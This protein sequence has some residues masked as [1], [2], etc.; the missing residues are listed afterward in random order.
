VLEPLMIAPTSTEEKMGSILQL[1]SF[2]APL[3]P[4]YI[5][6]PYNRIGWKSAAL[7]ELVSLILEEG[8]SIFENAHRIYVTDTSTL[9][10]GVRSFPVLIGDV[11][12]IKLTRCSKPA[13]NFPNTKILI[14]KMAN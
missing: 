5:P 7:W 3:A 1:V 12:A 11:G 10:R 2:G 13:S 14:S 9:V 6:P 4:S 8:Q